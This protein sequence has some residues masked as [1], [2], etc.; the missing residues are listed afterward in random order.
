[1]ITVFYGKKLWFVQKVTRFFAMLLF[2]K[3]VG[4]YVARFILKRATATQE[5][6]SWPTCGVTL[7]LSQSV[8]EICICRA[9]PTVEVQPIRQSSSFTID[10]P[11]IFEKRSHW[12]FIQLKEKCYLCVCVC[13]CVCVCLCLCVCVSVWGSLIHLSLVFSFLHSL[14]KSHITDVSCFSFSQLV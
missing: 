6:I 1:M 7:S 12:K 11:C 13:V 8:P 4:I 9:G 3:K 10:L 14:I 2:M 5:T